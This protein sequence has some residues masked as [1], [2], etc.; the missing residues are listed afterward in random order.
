M[1]ARAPRHFAYLLRCADG[2][3][4]AG[5]SSDLAAREARHNQGHGGR[6]TSGRLPVRMVYSE[7][8]DTQSAGHGARVR[9]QAADQT[10]ERTTR[11]S[12]QAAVR[13]IAVPYRARQV[14]R[15]FM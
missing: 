3:F 8:F 1:S 13:L 10:R 5:Y 2:T 4:Y 6:Y 15:I 12:A 7:S 14:C 11:A 9:A